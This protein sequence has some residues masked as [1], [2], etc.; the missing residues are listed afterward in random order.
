MSALARKA[1]Q[2]NVAG[3][4]ANQNGADDA[5][6]G[7]AILTQGDIALLRSLT[8]VSGNVDRARVAVAETL[9][10]EET[11][12]ALESFAHVFDGVSIDV[13]PAIAAMPESIK[14]EALERHLALALTLV[15]R[16][17]AL[18]VEPIAAVASSVHRIIASTPEDSTIRASFSMFEKRWAQLYSKSSRASSKAEDGTTPKP[19]A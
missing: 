9:L 11:L 2:T 8:A 1:V 14:L 3:K 7:G 15:H 5:E 17:L 13:K 12:S 19:D 6:R 4:A 18:H 10:D 16:H